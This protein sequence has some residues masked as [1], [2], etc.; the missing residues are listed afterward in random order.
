[1]ATKLELATR[2]VKEFKLREWI[3][4]FCYGDSRQYERVSKMT[5]DQLVKYMMA[6]NKEFLLETIANAPET[7]D[8]LKQRH[9]NEE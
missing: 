2:L 1:M 4:D 6:Y 5:D 8:V 7:L 3:Q 9:D